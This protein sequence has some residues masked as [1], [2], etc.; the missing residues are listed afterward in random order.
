MS[1]ISVWWKSAILGVVQGLTE[2][3]PISSSGHL[4]AFKEAL[5]FEEGSL[6]FD[7]ALHVA[8]LGAVVLYF[9]K[10]LW[11]LVRHPRGRIVAL[12]VVATIPGAVLG[13]AIGRWRAGIDPWW[14]VAG[15]TF[16]ATYLLASRG[17]GGEGAYRELPLARGLAI[18]MAQ[19]LAIFPGVSRSGASI[20]SGLWLGLE[21][22][23]ACRFSFL[24]SIP[25]IAGAGAKKALDLTTGELEELGGP[26]LLG[27]ACA[28]AVGLAAI[29]LLIGL[30]R[31]GK[32]H[33]FG[34]YNLTA[35]LVFAAFLLARAQ[36]SGSASAS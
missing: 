23:A 19:A 5:A 34:W 22:D 6:V 28:F 32:I 33:R 31:Q 10:D 15:W 35:A 1:E 12:V 17:R 21:R 7:V 8:T 36:A 18:G 14:V 24:I 20:T 26:L 4:I 27:M 2:F 29:H 16:S 25:L 3:L 9:R 13:A 11:S 30:V